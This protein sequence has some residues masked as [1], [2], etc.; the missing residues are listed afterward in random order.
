[1]SLYK[2]DDQLNEMLKARGWLTMDEQFEPG[3]VDGFNAH[4]GVTSYE[5]LREWAEMK[6]KELIRFKTYYD[7][8]IWDGHP[9]EEYHL[10][11][12]VNARALICNLRQIENGK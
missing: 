12:L 10:G 2:T 6:L 4:R 9:N 5:K 3:P 11:Q 7:L 8:G 1:M